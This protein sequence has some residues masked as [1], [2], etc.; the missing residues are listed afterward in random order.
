MASE[1][2]MNDAVESAQELGGQLVDS[3]REVADRVVQRVQKSY[4]SK[5]ALTVAVGAAAIV[6]IGAV[7]AWIIRR[8]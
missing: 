5:P 2:Q 7:A 8:N 1:K 3:G 6:V 4:E